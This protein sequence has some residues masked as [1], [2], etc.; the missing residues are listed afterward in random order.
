MKELD[1]LLDELKQVKKLV[2]L[3][4]LKDIESKQDKIWTLYELGFDTKSISEIIQVKPNSV[5]AAISNVKKKIQ[6]KQTGG[7]NG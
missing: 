5:L 4:A 2:A 3:S 6:K 7:S 1:P